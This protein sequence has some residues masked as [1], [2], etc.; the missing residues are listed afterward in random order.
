MTALAVT[1][2]GDPI[3][4]GRIT[5]YGRGQTV[6]SNAKV[7]EPWR[8]KI[9]RQVREEMRAQGIDMIPKDQPV[10]LNAI[11]TVARPVSV[12]V[13]ARWAPVVRPDLDHYVRALGDSLSGVL[14]EDDSQIVS[15]RTSKVYPYDG[16]V[17]GVTFTITPAERGESIAA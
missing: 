3:G 9:A 16:N 1:V 17:P 6:H 4:Q 8:Q 13:K 12:P 7:L 5:T 14:L 2:L 15:I 11:F 10:E